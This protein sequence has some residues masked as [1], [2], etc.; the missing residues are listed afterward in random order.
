MLGHPLRVLATPFAALLLGSL[1]WSGTPADAAVADDPGLVLVAP[2]SARIGSNVTVRATLTSPDSR[3]LAG[4]SVQ[5][6]R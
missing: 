3:P 1:L 6:Q 2:A 5:L 4:V